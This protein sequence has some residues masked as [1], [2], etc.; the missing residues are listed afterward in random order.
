M[1]SSY[2]A[3]STYV[4]AHTRISFAL[5][6]FNQNK[7]ILVKEGTCMLRIKITYYIIYFYFDN[8]Y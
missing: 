8:H 6:L 7:S 3:F 1:A 5:V 2:P 4:A